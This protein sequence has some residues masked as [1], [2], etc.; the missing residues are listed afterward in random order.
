MHLDVQK[1]TYSRAP[2]RIGLIH[3]DGRFQELTHCCFDRRR[4]ALAVLAAIQA[5]EA[6]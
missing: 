5:L 1:R 3:D 6:P 4:E 2:W